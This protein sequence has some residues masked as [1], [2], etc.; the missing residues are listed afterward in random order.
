MKVS[1]SLRDLPREKNSVVT[2]GTFDGVHLA[3]R[4]II[5]EV[6]NRARMR[7]GRSVVITFD[8]HPKEIVASDRGGEVRLL[9]TPEERLAL[10]E[11]L[12]VD[13]VFVIPFT[14]DFSRLTP[15][16]FYRQFVVSGVGVSEVVVGYDHMFGR[17]RVA[18]AQELVRMGKDFD[19]S[20]FA[21]HPVV[22]D[23][24]PV[25]STKIRRALGVGLIDRATRML[26]YPYSF[27]GTVVRGEGRG[28]SI[29]FPTANL[30]PESSKKMIPGRGVYAVTVEESGH[31]RFGMLNVGVRPT[32]TEGKTEIVEV[33]LFD[34]AGDLYDASLR[35]T[36]I[37]RLRDE[38]RFS[39]VP[40]LVGQLKTDREQ[41][42]SIIRDFTSKQEEISQKAPRSH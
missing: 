22:L 30:L 2:V 12:N 26:G 32:V 17:D 36:F 14:L 11:Q 19:F 35:V 8:P 15:E 31:R 18:G 4:E 20:V 40:E 29:G 7:E 24:D 16:E 41:A 23:G 39:G 38:R 33:H 10:L 37:A 9:C 6:V 28:R 1:R 5:R 13:L 25:S 3:H 34:F 21:V 42:L 27:A